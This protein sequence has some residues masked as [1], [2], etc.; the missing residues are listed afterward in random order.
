MVP[1]RLAQAGQCGAYVGLALEADAVGRLT[2][3]L[4]DLV[5]IALGG[6][7]GHGGRGGRPGSGG[8]TAA[9]AAASERVACAGC[10]LLCHA[11]AR[12]APPRP[13]GRSGGLAS[14]ADVQARRPSAP[15]AAG[16]RR[17]S[18]SGASAP[19][20]ALR[21]L[22]AASGCSAPPGRSPNDVIG[23]IPERRPRDRRRRGRAATTRTRG[24]D[25]DARRGAT[26]H[27]VAKDNARRRRRGRGREGRRL[28]VLR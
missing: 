5:R 10:L 21:S 19:P 25:E 1:V 24:D 20:R 13:I 14:P 16:P 17:F 2:S 27:H 6:V 18:V 8:R 9:V 7:H 23:Q 28:L 11:A 22:C 4:A 15:A 12:C 3:Q 26:Q